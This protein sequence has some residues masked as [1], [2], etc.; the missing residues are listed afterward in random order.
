M[1]AGGR[2]G[3]GVIKSLTKSTT[4]KQLLGLQIIIF[5]LFSAK[6]EKW[7]CFVCSLHSFTFYSLLDTEFVESVTE[8]A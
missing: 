3:K 8:P 7:R 6:K 1:A 5:N 2:G 4:E